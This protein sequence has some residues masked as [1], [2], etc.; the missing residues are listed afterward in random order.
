MCYSGMGK[1][2]SPY[3]VSAYMGIIEYIGELF[4][5]GFHVVYHCLV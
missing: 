3:T 2:P 4:L 5:P 1:S